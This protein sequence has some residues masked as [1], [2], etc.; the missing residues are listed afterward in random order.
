MLY[1]ASRLKISGRSLSTFF[2]SCELRTKQHY[3]HSI[4][5]IGQNAICIKRARGNITIAGNMQ[6]RIFSKL[7]ISYFCANMKPD[8]LDSSFSAAK[9]IIIETKARDTFGLGDAETRPL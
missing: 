5:N 6:N 7:A 8:Q 2:F 1:R 4:A 3:R 9:H